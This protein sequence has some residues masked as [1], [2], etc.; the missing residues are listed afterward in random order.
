MAGA[1][2]PGVEQT[3][4]RALKDMQYTIVIE[5]SPRNYAAYVP[6]LPG[7]VATVMSRDEVVREI[8][9]AIRFHIESLREHCEPVPEP[10][11]PAT[12][13]DVAAVAGSRPT[14][15]KGALPARL[16]GPEPLQEADR[17]GV[18]DP[19][20]DS[21]KK[22]QADLTADLVTARAALLDTV[23]LLD[24]GATVDRVLAT[25][26]RAQRLLRAGGGQ[27]TPDPE[28]EKKAQNRACC[29]SRR[30]RDL[31]VDRALDVSDEGSAPS[32]SETLA[33]V[34]EA[35]ETAGRV[36]PSPGR[37]TPQPRPGR[38][39]PAAQSDGSGRRCC[40]ST[41]GPAIGTHE[42][43]PCPGTRDLACP[44]ANPRRGSV[45]RISDLA[46]VLLPI[47]SVVKP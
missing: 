33:V 41:C 31:P 24:A 43:Q 26:H 38:G 13:V 36:R 2:P 27:I 20:L 45:T 19:H 9:H 44:R 3:A 29:G 11:C 8:N 15:P 6:D 25:V 17:K 21:L 10:Q 30:K 22:K 4:N 42:A 5:K 47:R 37:R 14:G 16:H 7:C 39:N 12:V 35:N 18:G 23:S 28:K 1:D 34:V 46:V 32:M 40:M